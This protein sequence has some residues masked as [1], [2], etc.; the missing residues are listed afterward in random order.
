MTDFQT[1]EI[2]NFVKNF[3]VF[4]ATAFALRV[5]IATAFCV[6]QLRQPR[7]LP[8]GFSSSKMNNPNYI[9]FFQGRCRF[10]LT[11]T[12][13]KSRRNCTELF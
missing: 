2:Q 4:P 13:A 5:E 10:S 7:G 9:R 11:F 8:A 12:R 3:P 6:V 1:F